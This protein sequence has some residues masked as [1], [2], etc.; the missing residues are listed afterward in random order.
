MGK[1]DS[2]D[3][4]LE[5]LYAPLPPYPRSVRAAQQTG[6]IKV[7]FTIEPDGTVK[8][9]AIVGAPPA[10]L[11]AITVNTVLRWRFAPI[12]RGGQPASLQVQQAFV[13]RIE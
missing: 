11:A 5:V 13:Y 6:T 9:P 3:A 1:V 10:V 2:L 4:P 12:T 8:D 7:R